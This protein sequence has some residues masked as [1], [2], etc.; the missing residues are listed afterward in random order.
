MS[1]TGGGVDND[2][3]SLRVYPPNNRRQ[4][5]GFCSAHPDLRHRVILSNLRNSLAHPDLESKDFTFYVIS[6]MMVM[7]I[8]HV[9]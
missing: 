8:I 1:E 6:N 2:F 9:R 4:N 3:S 7:K 5:G